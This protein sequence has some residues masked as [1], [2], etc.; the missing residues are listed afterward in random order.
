MTRH[1]NSTSSSVHTGDFSNS[2]KRQRSRWLPYGR[3]LSQR[4]FIN[5]SKDKQSLTRASHYW[6]E[7]YKQALPQTRQT[8]MGDVLV[9]KFVQA[10]SCLQSNWSPQQLPSYST[11]G[12]DTVPNP[13]SF[14]LLFIVHRKW[15]SCESVIVPTSQVSVMQ[16]RPASLY[17]NEQRHLHVTSLF[18][19]HRN[20]P[21]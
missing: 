17:A 14:F 15:K 13:T 10:V 12:I 19:N 9:Q 20:R 1:N 11:L 5:V 4:V 2:A 3:G 18:R 8:Y 6:K 16:I 7:E 21:G